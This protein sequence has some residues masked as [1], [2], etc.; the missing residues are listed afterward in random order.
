MT[1]N[2]CTLAQLIQMPVEEAQNLPIEQLVMLLEDAEA[3]K[4]DVKRYDTA[5]HDV[6]TRRYADQAG[7]ARKAAGKDTG[8]VSL[9][10]G[11]FIIKADLPS[12]VSWDEAG[13]VKVEASLKQMGEPVEDYIKFSRTVGEAAFK[14]WPS[15]LKALFRPHRTVSTGKQTFKVERKKEA[16]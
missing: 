11:D 6:L 1:T 16:A 7:Q 3:L 13:L 10:D 8:T 15:S 2:R 12:K 14:G 5:L 9:P 4:A